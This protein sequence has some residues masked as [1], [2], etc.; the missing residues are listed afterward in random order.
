MTKDDLLKE[1][2]HDFKYGDDSAPLAFQRIKKLFLNTCE[3]CLKETNG[4]SKTCSP[5]CIAKLRSIN[6][7]INIQK[8]KVSNERGWSY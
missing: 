7:R 6:S 2:L 5:A 4:K 8:G 3:I 1:I